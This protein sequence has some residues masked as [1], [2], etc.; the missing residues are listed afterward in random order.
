MNFHQLIKALG[1]GALLVGGAVALKKISETDS[2]PKDSREIDANGGVE[3]TNKYLEKYSKALCTLRE[4]YSDQVVLVEAFGEQTIITDIN[5]QN[6]REGEI[7]ACG[8][9][10]G[11]YDVVQSIRL[12]ED[13]EIDGYMK[14]IPASREVIAKFPELLEG[15]FFRISPKQRS[16]RRRLLSHS[17]GNIRKA[18]KRYRGIYPYMF[19]N[20]IRGLV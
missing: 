7:S 8:F 13:N 1:V 12:Y 10:L 19:Y 11:C 5:E 2:D 20:V 9:K 15:V 3:S 18:S 14:K 17:N 4:H 6:L 16:N